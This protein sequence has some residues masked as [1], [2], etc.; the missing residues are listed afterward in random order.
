MYTLPIQKPR[1]IFS[2]LLLLAIKRGIV[3][4]AY[5]SAAIDCSKY[6]V[7]IVLRPRAMAKCPYTIE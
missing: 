5:N 6:G 2:I 7:Y 4:I 3:R 1:V